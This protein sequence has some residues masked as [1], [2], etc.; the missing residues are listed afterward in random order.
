MTGFDLFV[1]G[2]AFGAALYAAVMFVVVNR[3][4]DKLAKAE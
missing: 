3:V 2:G 4:F 1:I